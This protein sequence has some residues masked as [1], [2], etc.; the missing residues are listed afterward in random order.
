MESVVRLIWSEGF[1]HLRSGTIA[2]SLFIDDFRAIYSLLRSN[3][4]CCD[5]LDFT[6]SLFV[7]KTVVKP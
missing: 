2:L 7:E 3:V 4:E 5:S 1:Y 6:A